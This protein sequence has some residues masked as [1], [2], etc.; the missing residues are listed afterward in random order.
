MDGSSYSRGDCDE[1]L[2]L[3]TLFC[4]LFFNGPYLVCLC[5]RSCSGNLSWQYVN[6]MSCIV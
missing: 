3:H 1:G 2:V 6:S 5:V 4:T